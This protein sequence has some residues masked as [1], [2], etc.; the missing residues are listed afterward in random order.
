MEITNGVVGAFHVKDGYAGKVEKSGYFVDAENN[1]IG[2]TLRNI[3]LDEK[4]E[5]IAYIKDG[6][7]YLDAYAVVKNGNPCVLPDF[8][9]GRLITDERIPKN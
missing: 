2:F 1:R 3:I 9:V 8:Y 6:G 7:V 4:S 5:R